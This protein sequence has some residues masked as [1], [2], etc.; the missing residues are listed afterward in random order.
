MELSYNNI[1]KQADKN[2][3]DME[4]NTGNLN[5]EVAKG[6]QYNNKL[7]EVEAGIRAQQNELDVIIS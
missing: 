5:Q 4:R 7:N 6:K 1:D 2:K 3:H